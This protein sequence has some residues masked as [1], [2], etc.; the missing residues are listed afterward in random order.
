MQTSAGNNN[1]VVALATLVRDHMRQTRS[2]SF[3]LADIGAK[4]SSGSIADNFSRLEVGSW[5]NVLTGGISVF[6]KFS[7]TRKPGSGKLTPGGQIP[8][9]IKTRKEVGHNEEELHKKFD[10]EIRFNYPERHYAIR[11][12]LV[13]RE[14][15]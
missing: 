15:R 7:D 9:K 4:D 14:V 3:T 5:S 12:T 8:W 6:F 1:D 13:K 10:G 11:V 2:T